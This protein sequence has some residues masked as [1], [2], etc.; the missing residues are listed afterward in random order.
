METRDSNGRPPL[1][2][3]FR[4]SSLMVTAIL[5]CTSSLAWGQS[6]GVIV[7]A[8]LKSGEQVILG[9]A[10]RSAYDYRLNEYTFDEI[11]KPGSVKQIKGL[12]QLPAL[13]RLYVDRIDYL[14]NL[15]W[16]RGL[17][18]LSVVV[19]NES[20]LPDIKGLFR[21]RSLNIAFLVNCKF[22][23]V[24]PR[25]IDLRGAPNLEAI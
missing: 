17:E 10:H 9:R 15:T 7:E 1:G 14:G 6:I 24:P 2:G 3:G 21:S 8:E 19:F 25:V 20:L 5:I 18:T 13:K 11:P 23:G 12:E 4:R 16:M 22:R